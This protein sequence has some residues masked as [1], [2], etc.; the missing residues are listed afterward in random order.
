MT[1]LGQP[2]Q[3]CRDAFAW[4]SLTVASE[5]DSRSRDIN[6]WLGTQDPRG[7]R[8]EATLEQHW[9]D[10]MPLPGGREA[11]VRHSSYCHRLTFTDLSLAALFK[12]QFGG[13][14]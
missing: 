12:L 7:F 4:Q 1:Q 13:V 9:Q 3:Q 8:E 2:T 14:Q 5:L 11:T 10:T 6:E